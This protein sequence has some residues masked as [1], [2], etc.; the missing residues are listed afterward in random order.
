MNLNSLNKA[1]DKEQLDLNQVGF[2]QDS[3]DLNGTWS[4]QEEFRE[5]RKNGMCNL[6]LTCDWYG[7]T[8]PFCRYHM[9]FS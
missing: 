2:T 9:L 8:E 3:P 7:L 1:D 5:P 4:F 6:R